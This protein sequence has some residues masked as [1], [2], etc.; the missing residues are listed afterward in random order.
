MIDPRLPTFP[1]RPVH[2]PKLD[3]R[4]GRAILDTALYGERAV[5][6]KWNGWRLELDRQECI[7]WNR[8]GEILSIGDEFHEAITLLHDLPASFPRYVDCE[9]L[10]RR[11][12]FMRGSLIVL[13]IIVPGL[14]YP[15]RRSHIE[16]EI[17]VFEE[18]THLLARNVVCATPWFPLSEAMRVWQDAQDLNKRLGTTGLNSFIEGVVLKLV[19][20]PYP[21][22]RLN[23]E[24]ETAFWTKHR[25]V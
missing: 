13:D 4:A 20:S 19:D 3:T 5:E 22:Q 2:G 15:A 21:M 24:R 10:E 25:F 1:A 17:P 7:P 12:G 23:P 9:C 11:H 8:H 18:S 16:A 14:K 6:F